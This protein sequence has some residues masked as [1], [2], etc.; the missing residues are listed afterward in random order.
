MIILSKHGQHQAPSGPTGAQDRGGPPCDFYNF[1]VTKKKDLE[2]RRKEYLGAG[3]K[4]EP[5]K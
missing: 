2:I 4:D 1:S 3:L 5:G